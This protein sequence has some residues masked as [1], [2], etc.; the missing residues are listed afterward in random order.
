[1]PHFQYSLACIFYCLFRIIITRLPLAQI[2]QTINQISHRTEMSH[3]HLVLYQKR[4]LANMPLIIGFFG[5]KEFV[6]ADTC[7]E[8]VVRRIFQRRFLE[9]FHLQYAQFQA[10]HFLAKS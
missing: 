4:F 9:L 1:M 6:F 10:R 5:S 3:Q 7:P 2:A 8:S